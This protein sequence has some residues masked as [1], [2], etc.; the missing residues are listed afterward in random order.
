MFHTIFDVFALFYSVT[1]YLC[2]RHILSL[3]AI[4]WP[5]EVSGPKSAI[6]CVCGLMLTKAHTLRHKG[7]TQGFYKAC[8]KG[9][10]GEEVPRAV[11]PGKLLVA[12]ALL[13][14]AMRTGN[15]EAWAQRAVPKVLKDMGLRALGPKEGASAGTAISLERCCNLLL[16]TSTPLTH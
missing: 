12:K 5:T 8:D 10:L 7:Q 6:P 11:G 13:Q 2:E 3:V 1:L 16:K 14:M 4:S 9:S 15:P